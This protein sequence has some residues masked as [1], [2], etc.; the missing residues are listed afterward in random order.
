MIFTSRKKQSTAVKTAETE[1]RE[2]E[3]RLTQ[4]EERLKAEDDLCRIYMINPDRICPSPNQPRA[5][6][7]EA[8][9]IA[10]ADSIRQLGI[11]QPLSVRR[12]SAEDTPLGGLYELIAGERRLRAAKLLSLP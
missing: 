8:S 10:L 2:R 7:D 3:R 4:R 6:F 1:L 9:I 12:I 5:E 11:I